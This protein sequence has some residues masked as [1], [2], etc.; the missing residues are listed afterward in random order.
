MARSFESM[1]RSPYRRPSGLHG[2]QWKIFTGGTGSR[3]KIIS[4]SVVVKALISDEFA[5]G[6]G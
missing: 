5:A 6:G 2:D 3:F 4:T 1:A